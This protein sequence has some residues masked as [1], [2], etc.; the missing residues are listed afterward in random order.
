M[1]LLF[2]YTLFVLNVYWSDPVQRNLK[3]TGSNMHIMNFHPHLPTH[4]L[5]HPPP[6]PPLPFQP[7]PDHAYTEVF[8]RRHWLK[9]DSYTVDAPLFAA[10]RAKLKALNMRQG[11]G[12]H[13]RGINEW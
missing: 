2:L 11:F 12:I 7:L 3:L 6:L 1:F 9:L 5:T 13:R 4:P 10:A 8:L